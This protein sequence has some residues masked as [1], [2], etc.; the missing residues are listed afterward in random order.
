MLPTAR[1]LL[2]HDQTRASLCEMHRKTN[3]IVTECCRIHTVA[4]TT[5]TAMMM[6]LTLMARWATLQ[7]GMTHWQL[8]A[9]VRPRHRAV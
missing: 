2:F 7:G 3:T 1:C 9:P 4:M 8:N 5:T 6:I